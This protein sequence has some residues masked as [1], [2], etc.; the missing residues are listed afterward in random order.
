MTRGFILA[1]KLRRSKQDVVMVNGQS[2]VSS[3]SLSCE[4]LVEKKRIDL[5]CLVAE[6]LPDFDVLLLMD[7]IERLVGVCISA[8]GRGCHLPRRGQSVRSAG[9]A[10]DHRRQRFQ[11]LSLRMARG[12]LRGNG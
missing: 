1:G 8:N 10:G 11:R 2:V 7:A 4:M 12:T 6:V 5:T 9:T 3:A